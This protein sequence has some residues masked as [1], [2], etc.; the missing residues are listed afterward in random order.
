MSN[1]IFAHFMVKADF[2]FSIGNWEFYLV[3]RVSIR[4]VNCNADF[5]ATF[6][7]HT[8]PRAFL[9][10]AI[11]VITPKPILTIFALNVVNLHE[12]VDEL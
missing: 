6:V 12:V 4:V 5:V 2:E 1:T 7:S 10:G 8:S 3:K 9:V 11:E